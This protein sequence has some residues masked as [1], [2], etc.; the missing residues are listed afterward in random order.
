M[1]SEI[2]RQ[3]VEPLCEKTAAFLRPVPMSP[4]DRL[5][6]GID[7][8]NFRLSAYAIIAGNRIRGSYAA[9]QAWLAQAPGKKQVG[10]H[11]ELP[12]TDTSCLLIDAN[13]GNRITFTTP[14]AER[15][16]RFLVLRFL[17]GTTAAETRAKF[18]INGEVPTRPYLDHAEH[19][20]NPYQ[21][22][23][24]LTTLG[25][26]GCGL[27][28][29][30]GTGKTPVSIARIMNECKPGKMLR[31]LVACPKSLRINW[32]REIQKFATRSGKTV[33]VRG[34]KIKRMHHLMDAARP[35][36][37]CDWSVC[38][39]SYGSIAGSVEEFCTIPWDLIIADESHNFKSPEAK[40]TKVMLK[41]RDAGR[42]RM[43]LTGTPICNRVFDLFTQ[44]EFMGEGLSG[45]HNF[46]AFRSFY[47]QFEGK[48]N[49]LVGYENLPLLQ[50]RLS[51][52][53]FTITKA[54][55]LPHLPSKQYG[56]REVSMTKR[57]ADLY[58]NLREQIRVEIENMD[59]SKSVTANNILTMLLR[60]AQITSG[61]VAWDQQM[62]E[63]GNV[64]SPREIEYFS[65]AKSDVLM[66][67]LSEL[68]KNSKAI[69]WACFVPDIKHIQS[70]LTE[71]GIRFVTY[72]GATSERD[73]LEAERAFNEDADCKVFI[74]N[75]SAC[76]E[77]LNLRGY[78][79]EME[80]NCDTVI[81][82]SQDWSMPKRKQSEDR[83]HRIGTRVPIQYWDLVVPNSVDEEIRKR[84][85]QKANTAATIQDVSDIMKTILNE[86][87]EEDDDE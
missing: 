71:A 23:A 39:A 25:V 17:A 8:N 30:Q 13:F 86:E 5:E 84:V 6:I 80:T 77:G 15:V 68:P 7:G 33:V 59:T 2:V 27:H 70:R 32:E 61:F 18:F 83:C 19:P 24:L 20:L 48:H 9:Q 26:D 60:L 56:L 21:K 49:T 41:L 37:D 43:N 16:Y 82:Y 62:D 52:L 57:Q 81:Y 12:I 51:R 74:G 28:M 79:G 31:V 36:D 34:G 29:E 78:T 38:I 44:F 65:T 4:D 54:Q 42:M 46:K 35:E 73:R 55:A 66:E 1:I 69:V 87:F 40:R 45:F 58:F 3:T 63:E 64:T 67:V 22:V 10:A 75:Q 72:Y 11:W 53:T 85:T 14:E 50:E 47:G 76:K